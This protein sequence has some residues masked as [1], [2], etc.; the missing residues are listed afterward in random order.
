MSLCVSAPEAWP[1]FMKAS[2]TISPID[3]KLNLLI[4]LIITRGR[5]IIEIMKKEGKNMTLDG[6][7]IIVARGFDHVDKK[8]DNLEDK[9]DK[10]FDHL[11]NRIDGVEL[12]ISSVSASWIHEFDRLH[13]WMEEIDARVNRLEDKSIKQ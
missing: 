9:F 1:S 7:A 13:D 11:E 10:K 5:S 8:F 12:K 3:M 6:L 2:V 4:L